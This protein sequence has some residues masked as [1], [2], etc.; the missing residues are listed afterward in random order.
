MEKKKNIGL[1]FGSFNPIH[2][3][4]LIVANH[5][6][7]H[8]DMDEVWFVI[9]PH[10]PFK[11]KSTL[12]S[13]YH[14]LEMVHLAIDGYEHFRACDEEFRLPKP[15]YTCDTLLHLTEKHP[16]KHFSLIMG[17]DSLV[18]FEKWKNYQWLLK[19]FSF[20]V[21]PRPG[22]SLSSSVFESADIHIVENAP[23]VEISATAIR[24][25]LKNGLCV[26][27]LLPQCVLHYI[28]KAGLYI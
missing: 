19:Y 17:A 21:Y 5:M 28:E 1:Y 20:Y 25:D 14:R 4:H 13:D 2:H 6:V 9:S 7:E 15:S 22:Y 10:N 3:G 8:T 11:K 18:G 23:Q 12:A 16:D 26:Q 24:E 27:S